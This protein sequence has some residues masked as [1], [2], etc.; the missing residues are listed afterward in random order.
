MPG[1]SEMCVRNLFNVA[2]CRMHWQKN[3]DFLCVKVDRYSKAKKAEDTGQWKYSVS[4]YLV[5]CL[6]IVQTMY[7]LSLQILFSSNI[8]YMKYVKQE[9]KYQI[10]STKH[11]IFN[12]SMCQVLLI[13]YSSVGNDQ[14]P[15]QRQ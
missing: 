8:L 2:D 13:A 3:G 14:L 9:L 12:K 4:I 11:F 5:F 10:I 15:F 1:R 7:L 6:V